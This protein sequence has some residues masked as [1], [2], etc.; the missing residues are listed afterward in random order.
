MSKELPE[1]KLDANLYNALRTAAGQ[2]DVRYY[3]NG[4]LVDMHQRR[5]AATDG[6]RLLIIPMEDKIQ[7]T[8]PE[9]AKG[10]YIVSHTSKKI[11][12]GGRVTLRFTKDGKVEAQAQKSSFADAWTEVLSIIDGKF[13]DIDRVVPD[14]PIADDKTFGFN[15][16]YVADVVTALGC[17]TPGVQLLPGEDNGA[18]HVN[19]QGY[20]DRLTYVVMPMRL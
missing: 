11:P 3:L 19:I 13:P 8:P 7:N 16:N 2:S 10:M 14:K 4:I 1:L 12:N 6:H 20:Q 18:I 15:P 9:P 17:R 5:Y